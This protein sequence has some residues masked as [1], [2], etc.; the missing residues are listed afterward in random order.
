MKSITEYKENKKMAWKT[1]EKYREDAIE[2]ALMHHLSHFNR[3]IKPSKVL[4][5][6]MESP[7]RTSPNYTL[8]DDV[9][10]MGVRHVASMIES[11]SIHIFSLAHRIVKEEVK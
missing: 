8:W 4:E 6:M 10:H 5:E 9:S 2:I 11:L 7:S 3:S 1:S